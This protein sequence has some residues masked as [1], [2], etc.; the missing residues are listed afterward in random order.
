MTKTT[1]SVL[2]AAS[3]DEAGRGAIQYGIRTSRICYQNLFIYSVYPEGNEA[4]NIKYKT[5]F[6]AFVSEIC[7]QERYPDYQITIGNGYLPEAATEFA[8]EHNVNCVIFGILPP[9]GFKPFYGVKFIKATKKLLCPFLTVKD[10]NPPAD[11]FK[12][13]YIPI[14]HKKEEKEKLIWAENF[15]KDKPIT[16]RL[17]PAKDEE[18]LAKAVIQSHL[19]FACRQFEANKIN[20]EI[21]TGTKSSYKI[22]QEAIQIASKTRDGILLVM[23]TK[24]YGPEQ[25]IFG[26]PEL[27]TIINKDNI[28]VI[29]INPR[30][31]LHVMYSKV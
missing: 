17:I 16:V 26:P 23:G 18:P 4:Q 1:D 6:E 3:L 11:L 7:I 13:L 31:D 10:S 9:S 25:D 30:R 15:C 19:N 5:D 28:A 22:D 12:N 14:S 20:Y 2:I 24:H 29:C 21:I 27:K 8:N